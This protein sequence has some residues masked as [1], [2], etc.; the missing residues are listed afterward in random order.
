MKVLAAMSGG[1]DSSVAASLMAEAGH[2]VSGVTL[3]LWGGDSDSGCCTV[4]DVDDAR[5]V[6]DQ[7]GISHHVFNMS[8]AFEEEVVAPYVD[9]HASGRTPNPCVECN[10]RIKFGLLLRRARRLGFD[11]VATGHHARVLASGTRL[12][13]ARGFDVSK[14][15]SYVLSMLSGDQLSQLAFPVGTLTKKQV[16]EHAAHLRLRTASKPDSQ[17]VCFIRSDPGRK[18]FLASR[19]SLT[20]GDLVEMSSG[21]VVG[22]VGAVELVTPGQRRGLGVSGDGSRRYAVSVDVPGRKV[23]VGSVAATRTSVVEL[24][25]PAWVDLPLRH[26]QPAIAQTSAHGAPAACTWR[27]SSIVFDEPQRLVAPGQTVA[28]YDPEEPEIVVGSAIAT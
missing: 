19:I 3:K 18:G 11:L 22:T 17:D 20:S 7:L 28:L 15:Q 23:L 12:R 1:V 10:R 13:L 14:D 9:E 4:A 25:R 26:G 2:D 6:A 24:A 27:T 16:R 5:R 8:D 21:E